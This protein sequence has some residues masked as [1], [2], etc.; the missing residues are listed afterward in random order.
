M[1][2]NNP[3]TDYDAYLNQSFGFHFDFGG[4]DYDQIDNVVLGGID[5][6]D[7]PDF[8]DAYIESADYYGEEMT[9]SEIDVLNQDSDFVYECVQKQLF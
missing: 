2:D 4:L 5:T 1:Y 9:E 6:K 8:C 7:Y 3:E